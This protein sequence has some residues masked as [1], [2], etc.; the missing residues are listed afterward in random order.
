[1]ADEE[2]PKVGS[3]IGKDIW[4]EEELFP[5]L[6]MENFASMV[7]GRERIT[8]EELAELKASIE[9]N[10]RTDYRFIKEEPPS[11]EQGQANIPLSDRYEITDLEGNFLGWIT[12]APRPMLKQPVA[13][14]TQPPIPPLEIP[15]R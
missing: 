1:M 12:T 7:L 13:S 4:F 10:S 15:I 14:A 9:A 8:D 5:S 2:K 6:D 11:D 3:D